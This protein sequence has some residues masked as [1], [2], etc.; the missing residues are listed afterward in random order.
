MTDSKTFTQLFYFIFTYKK[1]YFAS[2]TT[3][4]AI[5]EYQRI[6]GKKEKFEIYP[7]IFEDVFNINKEKLKQ[8]L[9]YFTKFNWVWYEQVDNYYVVQI[10]YNEISQ[11]RNNYLETKKK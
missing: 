1:F 2:R 8:V 11:F 6:Y 4:M 9:D 10:D 5:M 3:F 7:Y